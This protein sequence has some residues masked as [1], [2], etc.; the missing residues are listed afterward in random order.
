MIQDVCAAGLGNEQE[1]YGHRSVLVFMIWTQYRQETDQYS[2]SIPGLN[3]IR[4]NYMY[5]L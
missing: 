5:N 3:L 1:E 4:L 2:V